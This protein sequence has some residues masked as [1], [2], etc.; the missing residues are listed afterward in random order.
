M[1]LF[2]KRNP[3]PYCGG[4]V[5]GL[6]TFKVDGQYIC[7]ECYGWVDLPDGAEERMSIADFNAYRT[8]RAENDLLKQ[9][10]QITQKISFGW[11]D[12]KFVFDTDK[13]LMCLDD[14]LL[15]TVYEGTQIKSFVIKEDNRPVFEGSSAGLVSRL[16]PVPDQVRALEPQLEMLRLQAEVRSQIEDGDQLRVNVPEPFAKFNVEIRFEHPYWDV[17]AADMSG[18]SFDDDRPSGSDYIEEYRERFATMEQLARALKRIAF[19]E[20]PEQTVQSGGVVMGSAAPSAPVDAVEEIKRYKELLEQGAITE[21]EFTAKKK[22]LL[23]I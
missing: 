14:S 13:R 12:T 15:K 18:P 19:P 7:N 5:K 9:Q 22:Q 17:F 8:W 1:G 2:S 21:E 6:F 11:F 10:F 16:S 4:K 23:G 20:A 3:C